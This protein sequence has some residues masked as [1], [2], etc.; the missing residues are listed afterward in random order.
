MR[1]FAAAALTCHNSADT[2]QH[3][4]LA[5]E[6]AASG[7][8]SAKNRIV[9]GRWGLALGDGERVA[10]APKRRPVVKMMVLYL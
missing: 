7:T 1:F 9:H 4:P 6:C 8:G 2:R 10:G 3:H 5:T